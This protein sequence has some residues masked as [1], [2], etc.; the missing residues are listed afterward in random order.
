VIYRI[1][2]KFIAFSEPY[3]ECTA[4]KKA[5]AVHYSHCF[6]CNYYLSIY[7]WNLYSAT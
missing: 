4:V 5:K 7:I 6:I 2:R 3:K 1:N